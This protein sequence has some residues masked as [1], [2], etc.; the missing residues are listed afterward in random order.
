MSTLIANTLQGINTIKYDANTTAATID[1]SGNT[2]GTFL[3]DDNHPY[4]SAEGSSVFQSA[5]YLGTPSTFTAVKTWEN[6]ILNQA[7]LLNTTNGYMEIPSGQGGIYE[8]R[9]SSNSG[10]ATA[11]RGLYV[12][13]KS[14]GSVTN[15][16]NVFTMNDYSGYTIASHKILSLSA[17]DIIMVGYHNGYD[18]WS[19]STTYSTFFGRRIK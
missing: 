1:S 10:T 9:V 6:V 11:H 18:S 3:I 19:T 7:G 17:G 14:G 15:V 13:K 5:A 8:F 2:S 12:Y 16:D 4:F